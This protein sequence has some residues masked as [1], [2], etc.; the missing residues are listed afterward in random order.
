MF[1]FD[2]RTILLLAVMA[3]VGWT[4]WKIYNQERTISELNSSLEKSQQSVSNLTEEV[5]DLREQMRI[6]KEVVKGWFETTTKLQETQRGY[7]TE[8][9]DVLTKFQYEL[10]FNAKHAQ[11]ASTEDAELPASSYRIGDSIAVPA[12]DGMWNAFTATSALARPTATDSGSIAEKS[13]GGT[14]AK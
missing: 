6:D 11:S 10:A 7:Q 2:L 1:K 8:V 13:T 4:Q 9:Q 3:I 14:S 5:N 12:I